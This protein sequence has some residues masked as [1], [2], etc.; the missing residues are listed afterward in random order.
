ME[1]GPARRGDSRFAFFDVC[2]FVSASEGEELVVEI[3]GR[4]GET[5]R[6]LDARGNATKGAAR[7]VVREEKR[8]QR[9]DEKGR[10]MRV[11][12]RRWLNK[13]A[14]AT[15]TR[16]EWVGLHGPIHS[17]APIHLRWPSRSPSQSL[18]TH[19]F[20]L[21]PLLLLVLAKQN[22]G[23][24]SPLVNIIGPHN[25]TQPAHHRLSCPKNPLRF[26]PAL[27]LSKHISTLN[28]ILILI[29]LTI[30]ITILTT[31]T[32]QHHAPRPKQ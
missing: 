18:S 19:A 23:L 31:T 12:G 26:T 13:D 30:T 11:G 22:N 1:Q 7:A 20:T 10:G 14:R 32:I 29:T 3:I 5:G 2:I 21:S 9:Q 17:L 4:H 15:A 24:H 27:T 8:G 28:I 25:V 6:E 16:R